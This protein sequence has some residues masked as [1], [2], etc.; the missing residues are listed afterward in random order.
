VNYFSVHSVTFQTRKSSKR[1]LK[2]GRLVAVKACQWID[3][4]LCWYY[5]RPEGADTAGMK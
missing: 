3:M 5:S 2:D 1:R 4:Q